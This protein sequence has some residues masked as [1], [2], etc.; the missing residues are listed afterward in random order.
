MK[1][2]MNPKG[3]YLTYQLSRG[4]HD[5]FLEQLKKLRES[6]IVFSSYDG[7]DKEDSWIKAKKWIA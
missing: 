7:R 6:G 1:A 4:E 5:S 2:T 3:V